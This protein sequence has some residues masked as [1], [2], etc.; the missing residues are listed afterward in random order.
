MLLQVG[1]IVLV[2]DEG[3]PQGLWKLAEVSSHITGQDG[4][5]QE[6]FSM[7]LPVGAMV[8]YSTALQHLSPLELASHSV[9]H[10]LDFNL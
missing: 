9:Q 8:F 4:H 5:P 6:L 10:E 2:E 3:R 1:D 7:F